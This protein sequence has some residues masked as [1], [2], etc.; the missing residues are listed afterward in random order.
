MHPCFAT[1]RS[2][3]FY[4][5][6][7]ANYYNQTEGENL[8]QTINRSNRIVVVKSSRFNW[9]SKVVLCLLW[10]CFPTRSDW[11]KKLAPL[12]Q[13]INLIGRDLLA[14][15]F[16]GLINANYLYLLQF[17]IDSFCLLFL[18]WLARVITMV[19]VLWHSFEKRPIRW[20]QPLNY[21]HARH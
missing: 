2:A 17:L 21:T 1:D 10:F 6:K 20:L 4:F 12:S 7:F 11:F 16:P 19:L 13:Q 9:V 5:S 14:R 3:K 18:S 15:V 8:I